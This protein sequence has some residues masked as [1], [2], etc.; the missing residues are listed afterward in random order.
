M[1]YIFHKSGG[2]RHISTCEEKHFRDHD[3]THADLRTKACPIHG[4]TGQSI[5]DFSLEILPWTNFGD[6]NASSPPDISHRAIVLLRFIMHMG[7]CTSLISPVVQTLKR[8]LSSRQC[9]D[10]PRTFVLRT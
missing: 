9:A 4:T 3:G 5:E 8:Q 10:N 6:L 1:I 2:V 7:H